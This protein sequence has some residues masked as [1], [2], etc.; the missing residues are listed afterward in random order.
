VKRALAVL[1]VLATIAVACSSSSSSDDAAE[2]PKILC[3][4]EEAQCLK[5]LCEGCIAGPYGHCPPTDFAY[6]TVCSPEPEASFCQSWNK[7]PHEWRTSG[8][9]APTRYTRNLRRLTGVDSC[10]A[11]RAGAA[12]TNEETIC[13]G[14]CQ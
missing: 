3:V 7:A 6:K 10:D 11:F 1:V 2:D 8:T 12:A 5:T 4:W 9:V 14:V 13:D